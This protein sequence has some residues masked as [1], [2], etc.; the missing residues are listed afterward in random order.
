MKH[1]VIKGSIVLIVFVFRKKETDERRNKMKKLMVLIVVM[2]SVSLGT[3][4]ATET[5]AQPG[6]KWKGS[7]GWGA[8]QPYSRMYNPQA[9]ETITGD[10]V[11]IDTIMPM[12][13]MSYGL[14]IVERQIKKRYLFILVLAGTSQIRT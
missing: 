2:I 10:V 8:E 11:S 3:I 13:G 7:G 6:M 14:H 4:T 9:V 5:L 1:I 12:K